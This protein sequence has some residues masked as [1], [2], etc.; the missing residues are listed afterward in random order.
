MSDEVTNSFAAAIG[1]KDRKTIH[2][3]VLPILRVART[4]NV[5]HAHVVKWVNEDNADK[6]PEALAT[7][8]TNRLCARQTQDNKETTVGE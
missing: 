5:G 3:A 4:R 7:I 1:K 6:S 8:L 2:A